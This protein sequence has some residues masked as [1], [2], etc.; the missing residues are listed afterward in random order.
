MLQKQF[1][2][3]CMPKNKN[4]PI[5]EIALYCRSWE[6]VT[7]I[8]GVDFLIR[9]QLI[10]VQNLLIAGLRMNIFKS[11]SINYPSFGLKASVTDL[12]PLLSPFNRLPL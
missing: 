5:T 3:S 10:S 6:P 12:I 11:P 7:L 2:P 4:K 1:L 9:S 8:W